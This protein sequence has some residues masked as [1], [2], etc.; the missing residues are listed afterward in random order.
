MLIHGHPL[1]ALHHDLEI[2]GYACSELAIEGLWPAEVTA[3]RERRFGSARMAHARAPCVPPA[4][5]Q[6]SLCSSLH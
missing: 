2:R 1:R 5:T 4:R 3:Y 6:A